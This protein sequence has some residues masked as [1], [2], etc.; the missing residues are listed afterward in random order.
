MLLQVLRHRT[1]ILYVAD[2]SLVVANLAL[3][4]GKTVL[5]SGTGSGSLTHSLARAVAPHGHVYTFDFHQLRA[6]EAQAEFDRHSL[7]GMVVGGHHNIEE[8]GFPQVGCRSNSFML[9]L[10]LMHVLVDTS[11][12][13]GLLSCK[14]SPASMLW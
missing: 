10:C 7:S 3:T 2:I 4:P 11:R 9:Q 1:Q 14:H 6:D 8:Q 12:L 5:E 13:D